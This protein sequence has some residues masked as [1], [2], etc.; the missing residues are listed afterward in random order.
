MEFALDDDQ[1]LVQR[2]FRQ[3][4]ERHASAERVR[5][6]EPLGFDAALW[7]TLA[8]AGVPG[9][10][11]D[12]SLLDLALI[13]ETAGE[14]AAPAPLVESLVATRLLGREA[15]LVAFAPRPAAADGTVA[16]VPGAAVAP[17][18]VGLADDKLVRVER[19]P[20]MTAPMTLGSAPL[21]D[22]ATAL[23]GAR[24]LTY[25]A[26]WDGSPELASMAF[27]F[28]A[29]AAQQSAGTALHVHGGYGFM[30]EYDVQLFFCRAKAWPLALGDPVRELDRIADLRYGRVA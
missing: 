20:P 15:G 17:L 14:R 28:A 6:A 11:L 16:L 27:A 10:A 9:L 13:A 3:L 5:A 7:Q 21:A 8:G 2:T 19:E 26:A 30:L 18:V 29:E 25:E 1:A 4:F 22:V 23:D 24:L 12:A